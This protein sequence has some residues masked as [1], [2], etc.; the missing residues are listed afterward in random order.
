MKY[1]L[2][3]LRFTACIFVF[4]A[5]QD[6]LLAQE[7]W[8]WETVISNGQP[9]ARHE[10]GLVAYKDKLLLIGGRR[11]NPTDEFDTKTNAW[12]A[13]KA[14]PIELHHFQPVVIDD[15][16]Y[17]IGAMTG[18]WP[19]EKPLERVI[20]YYPERDE[21]V[22]S[23]TIPE[24]RRRGG[25]GAVVYKGKIYVVGGITNGHMNGYRPWLDE[26]DPRTGEWR[27]LEDAPNSRDHFQAVVLNDKLYAFAGRRSSRKTSEDMKL[28]ISHG[29]IYD[30]ST[31]RWQTVSNNLAI[32]TQRAGNAAFAWKNE[33]VVGGGESVVQKQ[34]HKEVEAFNSNTGTWRIWPAM[35]N[36]RHGTGYAVIGD[37]VYIASGSG[38]RG[39]GPELTSLERLKLP[40]KNNLTSNQGVDES[41]VYKQWHT[42]ELSFKGPYTSEKAK[43]NPFLNYA[44]NVE[45]VH[46]EIKYNVRGYYAADGNADESGADSGNV[47]QVRFVPDRVGK[48]SYTAQLHKGDSI[49]LEAD[50]GK[51]QSDVIQAAAGN[52][53]VMTS[54]K[55][56][57]DFRAKGRLETSNGYFRFQNSG[58][59]WLKGGADSPENLL[60]YADFDGTY[61][62]T[63]SNKDGEASTTEK[64]HT[65]APHLNDWQEGDPTWKNGKGKSLIGALNYLSSKE[66]NVVYFLAMNIKGD[67]K[68]VWPYRDPKDFARFDVSKL[69]QWEIVFQHM[70]S[71]GL[72][73][74]MVLQE[75]ENETMLDNGD[76]GVLRQLYLREMM[77]RFGHHLALKFNLGEENGFADFTP[78]AQNDAQ[79][80]AMASFIKKIDP[81]GHPVLLHTHSHEPARTNVLDSIV[82]FADLDGL[83]L[84][85]DHR[86]GVARIVEEWKNKSK[87]SG[88]N[89][90]ITMDEIGMWHTGAVSDSLTPNHDTLRRYVLWGSLLS[91]AAGVE[92]YFGANNKHNDLN[93]EDWRTRDRLWDLTYYAMAFF[94]SHIPYWEM[95]PEHSLINSKNAYC[96]RKTS[97][98]Y[99][100]Y[101]PSEGKYTIDLREAKGEFSLQWFDPLNGGELQMG[102][103]KILNGGKIRDLGAPPS[104]SGDTTG[105]QD[106]VALIKKKE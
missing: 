84:Q 64:I 70:Q 9:T 76:T 67:G 43:E 89:W 19:N 51:A 2:P 74:H 15:A 31:G 60:A 90:L 73:L 28:T 49:A 8:E 105:T 13:K 65:Y 79:R 104:V 95:V 29:N 80:K 32:P 50:L 34:A 94:E 27:V 98:V 14:T 36:G 6:S 101:L 92:W 52:F 5:V 38:N 41:E 55:E 40:M 3:I 30:F 11:I 88:H 100:V 68:D 44:L 39:G 23:H 12:T 1:I 25:A 83:S 20:I 85:V 57:T 97:E 66:M 4:S 54:D 22:Y 78:I 58:D 37:Y 46:G 16:V 69:E 91:G 45:F 61:R 17:L 102:A 82:G 72:M 10:A 42:I 87:S 71:R 93:T 48:W 56:G 75:T 59:Y 63:T 77:A 18:G 53:M 26:Y 21:Y 96:F 62:M 86:E 33:I 24:H 103:V 99:V 7:P 81:Y 47:W 35:Q 106:W